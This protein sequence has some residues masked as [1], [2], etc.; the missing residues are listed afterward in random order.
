VKNAASAFLA[1]HGFLLLLVIA[2]TFAFT[3]LIGPFVGAILW[4]VIAAILAAPLQ[5]RLLRLMPNRRNLA[6]AATLAIIIAVA[7][8]PALLL[9]VALLDQA[10][11][12]F[13]QLKTG[14]I[15]LTRAFVDIE[16]RLPD[17]VRHWLGNLGLTDFAALQSRIGQGIATSF[18]AIAAQAF[19]VGQSTFG[20]FVSLSVMLYLTFF[21]L[22][23]GPALVSTIERSLPLPD[24]QRRL[25]VARFVAVVRATIKGSV[26]VA[27]LQGVIGGLIFWFLGIGGALLWGV[28]MAVFSLFPAIGT[29]LIWAPVAI[30]LFATGDTLRASILFLCGFVII[31]SVDNIVRPILVG[32][33]AR[34]PDYL[35]LIATLGGFVLMGFNGFVIGPVIA[36][37]F[38]AV[39]EIFTDARRLHDDAVFLAP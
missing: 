20:F 17:V 25:L 3:W 36:A 15:D 32:R 37:M 38:M 13:E 21:L 11:T 8:I 12:V 23:D 1:E 14:E 31:S 6:A 39:W 30:Y 34:M 24:M 26:I 2:A 10:S 9:S 28:A 19:V 18:K 22:R 7:I 5:T 33:D 27:I 35:V 29:G 4:G 16:R